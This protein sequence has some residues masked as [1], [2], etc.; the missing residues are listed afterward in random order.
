VWL[1]PPWVISASS[2]PSP[3]PGE[4]SFNPLVHHHDDAADHLKVAQ[5][6][7]RD[8]EQHVLAA[9]IAF[10]QGLTKIPHRCGELPLRPAKLLQ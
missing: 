8:I 6:L 10:C 5:L 2:S 3:V 7:S 1:S 9:G 4:L